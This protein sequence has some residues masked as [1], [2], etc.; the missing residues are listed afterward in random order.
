MIKDQKKK[1]R[2]RYQ[3]HSKEEKEKKQ[4]YVGERYKNLLE[5]EK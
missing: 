5:N 3:S 2:E 4:Q 1:A